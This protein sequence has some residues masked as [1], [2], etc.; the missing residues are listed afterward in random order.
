M[1]R[2]RGGEGHV[3]SDL[4][5]VPGRTV[6]EHDRAGPDVEQVAGLRHPGQSE[7][8]F[9]ARFTEQDAF[10]RA[11][12]LVGAALV[13]DERDAPRRPG[14][15]VVVVHEQGGVEPRELEPVGGP[16]V[17]QPPEHAEAHAVGR[18]SAGDPVGHPARTHR[19]AVARLEVPAGDPPAHAS[20]S[21]PPVAIS[22]TEIGVTSRSP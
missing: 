1:N 14:L 19:V 18:A 16:F 20:T 8:V 10:Q 5:P 9:A 22:A 7:D 2:L 6:L 4:E 21:Q 11:A 3:L 17:D 12:L 13:E 15:V